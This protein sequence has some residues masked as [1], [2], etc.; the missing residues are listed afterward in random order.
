MFHKIVSFILIYSLSFCKGT[1]PNKPKPHVSE[2]AQKSTKVVSNSIKSNTSAKKNIIIHKL[3]AEVTKDSVEESIDRLSYAVRTHADYF[4]LVINSPGGSVTAGWKLI[5]AIESAPIT[6]VC[7]VSN[8][9]AS[10]AAVITESCSIRAI[11]IQ[12]SMMWHEPSL[13]LLEV[14]GQPNEWESLGQMLRTLKD[15]LAEYVSYHFKKVSSEEYNRRTS[16]GLMWWMSS[17]EALK[18]GAVDMVVPSVKA[19]YLLLQ[20][21]V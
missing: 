21:S 13:S 2:V 11:T 15:G 18:Y 4:M 19:L 20:N 10:M 5:E 6:T 9:A 3:D 17:K 14:S 12:G 16:G 1:P 7:L 8:E